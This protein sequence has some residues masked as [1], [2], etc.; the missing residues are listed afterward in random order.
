MLLIV[1][2]HMIFKQNFQAASHDALSHVWYQWNQKS[3]FLTLILTAVCHETNLN[4]FKHESY[5]FR[6]FKIFY[7]ACQPVC[8]ILPFKNL[9]LKKKCMPLMAGF[10]T[11]SFI[12]EWKTLTSYYLK[13]VMVLKIFVET[14]SRFLDFFQESSKEP[15]IWN[16]PNFFC[17]NVKVFKATF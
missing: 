5:S 6:T 2:N 8:C 13:I 11:W 12:N 14:F 10:V 4:L 9:R 1:Q 15:F 16:R 17:N 3:L 7:E